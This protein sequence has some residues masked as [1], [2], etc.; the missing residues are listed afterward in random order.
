M[1][2][3]GLLVFFLVVHTAP[4]L[5]VDCSSPDIFLKT[6]AEVNSFQATYGS[7]GVCDTV[8]G[9][10]NISEST[11]ISDLTPLKDIVQ[12][13]K[14][15]ILSNE[16][17][18]DLNGL[19]AL[20]AVFGDVQINDNVSLSDCSSLRTLL[21]DT[22]DAAPGPGPGVAGIPDV[23]GD[24]QLGNL[25]GCNSVD[26][27]LNESG[28][29]SIGGT[30]T[31]LDGS[32]LVLQNNGGD[33]LAVSRN[34]SFTFS[35]PLWEGS[36]YE[37]TVKFQP[38]NPIQICT[39]DN[40][41]GTVEEDDVTD[42]NVSC[43]SYYAVK[44]AV[45]NYE[46]SGLV[47]QNNGE[48]DLTVGRNSIFRFPTRV[49]DGERYNVTVKER[50][51]DPDQICTV[52]NG[53]GTIDGADVENV[54][55]KCV[56]DT[57]SINAGLNDAWFNPDTDGQGFLITVLPEA[58][59]VFLA[60]YT[61][62]TELPPRGAIANLGD[63]G[64]RWLTAQGSYADKEAVL[65]VVLTSGG[66]FDKATEVVRTDPA[67]SDGT[68]IL[69]FDDCYTGTIEYDIPSIGRRGL[70]PIQRIVDDNVA[71]CEAL[72][73][74]SIIMSEPNPDSPLQFGKRNPLNPGLN[75]A[76]FNVDTPGQGIFLSVLPVS[77]V[78]FLA[79]FTYDTERPPGDAIANLGDPGHRWLTAQ[80]IYDGGQA[81]LDLV[82][83]S[84]GL[85]D[86][87]TEVQRTDP[88]G[89][90]GT[91]TLDFAD[92]YS[93]TLEYDIPSIDRQGTVPIQRIVKDNIPLCEALMGQ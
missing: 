65:D 70:I 50:P 58:E 54:L 41:T 26:E 92:C 75:D 17:L 12:V 2:K 16:I 60:W 55:V 89:S 66:V 29:Y 35:Q 43:I 74:G 15:N 19:S 85:F 25:P 61:Y 56:I 57:F 51:E 59:T 68:L 5:A 45:F 48:D 1:K 28:A 30:L 83:T 3:L 76:W 34:G 62:D 86:Y 90:D 21:D 27:I 23:G 44:G 80:G 32:G 36:D 22:D 46:G 49:A 33:D 7:G 87:S 11:D 20:V 77:E 8:T 78:V 39:V 82:V 72:V 31:G 42:I 13:N 40:G 69:T 79:W 93:G 24:V 73:D 91:I 6:Q 9:S 10:L 71:V 84:G 18:T 67:G 47:L 38:S 63:P 52:S 81:V 14:L 4:V 53:S 88:P 37:V 64:H